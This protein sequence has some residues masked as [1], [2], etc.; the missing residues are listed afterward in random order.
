MCPPVGAPPRTPLANKD[1]SPILCWRVQCRSDPSS[2]RHS[3]LSLRRHA[4][5]DDLKRDESGA[6]Q[7]TPG[8]CVLRPEVLLLRTVRH[9]PRPWRPDPVSKSGFA[10]RLASWR[11]S[12][13]RTH[14]QR[15]DGRQALP[16]APA[17]DVPAQ[18]SLE[19]GPSR[20]ADAAPGR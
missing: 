10:G 15:R 4:V 12:R 3:L 9:Y 19:P 1:T 14:Q 6:E 18:L 5:L 13:E 16:S 20:P 8:V 7:W 2:W 11:A 17:P